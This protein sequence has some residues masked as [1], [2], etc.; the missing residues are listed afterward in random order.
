MLYVG[1]LWFFRKITILVFVNK[2]LVFLQKES[3][4]TLAIWLAAAARAKT[5]FRLSKRQLRRGTPA[6]RTSVTVVSKLHLLTV[7]DYSAN[8]L[9]ERVE[10]VKTSIE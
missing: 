10:R 1:I 6:A 9:E 3:M 4:A 2:L 8:I 7:T 5:S